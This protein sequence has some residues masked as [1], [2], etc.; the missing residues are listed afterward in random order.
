MFTA[1]Q[2]IDTLPHCRI[3]TLIKE[4]SPPVDMTQP[5]KKTVDISKLQTK[6]LPIWH[7][8][9]QS[10]T[11]LLWRGAGGE[12]YTVFNKPYLNSLMIKNKSEASLSPNLLCVFASLREKNQAKRLSVLRASLA[13][14]AV[15]TTLS[16]K[17]QPSENDSPNQ[18]LFIRLCEAN[19]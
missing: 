6:E 3:D 12:D 1:N 16:I 18:S 15:K 14:F 2:L 4:M 5:W 9:Q 11:P 10:V 13:T 17:C 7:L 19:P 8:F